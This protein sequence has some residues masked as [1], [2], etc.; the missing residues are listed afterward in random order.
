MQHLKLKNNQLTTILLSCLAEECTELAECFEH[1]HEPP[2]NRTHGAQCEAFD[3]RLILLGLSY[4]TNGVF[5]LEGN[6]STPTDCFE[7]GSRKDNVWLLNIEEMR[8][9]AFKSFRFG[10]DFKKTKGSETVPVA[11]YDRVSVLASYFLSYSSAFTKYCESICEEL[12]DTY[13][14]EKVDKFIKYL[15]HSFEGDSQEIDEL[16]NGIHD[17]YVNL[18]GLIKNEISRITQ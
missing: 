1:R 5:K 2:V 15:Y 4:S 16:V 8:Y 6:W 12:E 10:F 13:P 7:M 9:Y 3:V 11:N 17:Y 18:L 14:Q